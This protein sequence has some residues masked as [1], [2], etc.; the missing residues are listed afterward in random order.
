[1][2]VKKTNGSVSEET[3]TKKVTIKD[4]EDILETTVGVKGS[5][6]IR[7]MSKGFKVGSCDSRNFLKQIA[8]AFLSFWLSR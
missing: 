2:Y 7:S 5:F 8:F 1:M 4:W 3:L 6:A